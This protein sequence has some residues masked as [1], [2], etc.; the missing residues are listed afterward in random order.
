[1]RLHAGSNQ[2]STYLS[3]VRSQHRETP[4][5]WL[6]NHTCPLSILHQRTGVLICLVFDWRKS[7]SV[8]TNPY[9]AVHRINSYTQ[10]RKSSSLALVIGVNTQNF[11][12][13]FRGIFAPSSPAFIHLAPTLILQ[14]LRSIIG[15]PQ[16]V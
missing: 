12:G 4:R 8:S 16:K 5:S 2:W 14:F 6:P 3:H 9:T 1:M 10:Q 15:S 7:W 13:D 11:V